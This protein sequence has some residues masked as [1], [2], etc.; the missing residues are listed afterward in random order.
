MLKKSLT[1][2]TLLCAMVPMVAHAASWSLATRVSTVGGT[3]SSRNTATAQT[4]ANG[5]VFKTYTTSGA[6]DVQVA[7]NSGYNVSTVTVNGIAKT[8][9]LAGTTYHMGSGADGVS[10]AS[11]SVVVSFV[12]KSCG[13]PD[14]CGYQ[15]YHRRWR[16]PCG[17][18]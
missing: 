10:R 9:V 11:Q 4:S 16:V 7:P 1:L 5:T 8:P 14:P 13:K 3:I 2:I 6:I 15:Q 12:K 18:V 17:G